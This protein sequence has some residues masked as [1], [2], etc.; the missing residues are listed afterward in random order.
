MCWFKDKLKPKPKFEEFKTTAATLRSLIMAKGMT[1]PCWVFDGVYFYV[2]HEDWGA[3]FADVLLN[4]PAYTTQKFDCEDFAI[5]VKARV[6]E[7]YKLNTV[8]VIIGDVPQGRHGFNMFLSDKG[9]FLLEP[10]TGDVLEI[11]EKGYK[12][13]WALI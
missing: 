11:G 4:M 5:L 8:A 6:S 7:R 12:P 13:E 3:I 10:Q 2:S 9:L 1:M